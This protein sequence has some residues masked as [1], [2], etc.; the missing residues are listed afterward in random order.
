MAHDLVIRQPTPAGEVGAHT[1]EATASTA[2]NSWGADAIGFDALPAGVEKA[3]PAGG[4]LAECLIDMPG[5]VRLPDG[6]YEQ[7]RLGFRAYPRRVVVVRARRTLKRR[8]DG[9]LAPVAGWQLGTQVRDATAPATLR[10][11]ELPVG[12]L[13]DPASVGTGGQSQPSREH[14]E[15]QLTET[16][17]PPQVRASLARAVPEPDV[18]VGLL[19]LW[20]VAAS[21]WQQIDLLRLGGSRAV[22]V[23]ATRPD[24]ADAP[25]TIA[26]YDYALEAPA[27]RPQ[28]GGAR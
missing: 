28:I 15:G 26:Q 9:K 20:E 8:S 7:R 13:A 16:F 21:S 23:R 22:A 1:P 18:H 2:G 4:V 27:S 6:R 11:G 25:W 24:R 19:A 12:H 10:R 17:L 3:A 14:I 5:A